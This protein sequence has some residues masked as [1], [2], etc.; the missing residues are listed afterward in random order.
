MVVKKISG[1]VIETLNNGEKGN[2]LVYSQKYPSIIHYH[3]HQHLPLLPKH[4]PYT[5]CLQGHSF[6]CHFSWG[7]ARSTPQMANRWELFLNLWRASIVL[8]M[9]SL[10]QVTQQQD[11]VTQG[12]KRSMREWYFCRVLTRSA[13]LH[14][15]NHM[16]L[17]RTCC[18]IFTWIFSQ[19]LTQTEAFKIQSTSIEKI[20]WPIAF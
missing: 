14:N 3:I 6:Y 12:R 10:S 11:L 1:N 16:W 19:V 17:Q 4:S 15:I 20:I 13:W 8:F 5:H 18:T 9:P 2:I 7:S